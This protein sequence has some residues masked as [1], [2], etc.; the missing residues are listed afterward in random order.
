MK[1]NEI[2]K[3]VIRREMPDIEQ[4]RA[5]CINQETVSA[6]TSK[7]KIAGKRRTL[8][9]A[10]ISML[11]LMLMGVGLDMFVVRYFNPDG[12]S[13]LRRYITPR[14]VER[15]DEEWA[16]L[17][18]ESEFF[19]FHALENMQNILGL[20]FDGGW[21]VGMFGNHRAIYD[22]DEFMKFM[23]QADRNIFKLPQY[24]PNGY[25]FSHAY[26]QFYI[27]ENFD[28]KNAELLERVEKFGNIYLKYYIP[29]N[30][31]TLK[32]LWIFYEKDGTSKDDNGLPLLTYQV[33]LHGPGIENITY[34]SDENTEMEILQMPQFYRSH[35]LSAEFTTADG[36]NRAIYSFTAKNETSAISALSGGAFIEEYREIYR[37]INFARYGSAAYYISS[38]FMTREE[39][40]RMAES[41]R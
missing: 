8:L 27:D 38:R 40:I 10:A 18:W 21:H 13:F 22:Y 35:L 39:I 29:E 30:P 33:Q 24:I 19:E 41:I 28:F 4:V 26:L 36:E 37:N 2:F 1:R 23:A 14:P 34:T 6:K 12:T 9:I 7:P 25:Q 20:K 3:Q 17:T 32:M 16:I 11:M 5:N 31:A 15:T